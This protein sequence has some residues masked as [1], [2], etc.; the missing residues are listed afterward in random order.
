MRYGSFLPDMPRLLLGALLG[1]SVTV[2]VFV[3]TWLVFGGGGQS[4]PVGVSA[5]DAGPAGP[6]VLAEG[7]AAKRGEKPAEGEPT[8]PKA[9]ATGAVQPANVAG[10]GSATAGSSAAANPVPDA[11]RSNST[12]KSN[13]TKEPAPRPASRRFE[14][15]APVASLTLIQAAIWWCLVL[16]LLAVGGCFGSFM[17]VVIYRL[18]A[19]LSLMR[20]ASRCPYCLEGI[21]GTDNVPVLSWLWLRGQCRACGGAI[22]PRYPLIE[23]LI[24]F[25]CV[26]LALVEVFPEGQG[27]PVEVQQDLRENPWQLWTMFAG[28]LLLLCTLVCAAG[29]QIDGHPVP[30][31]LFIPL[32]LTAVV[33]A[34]MV[35]EACRLRWSVSA[36]GTL[37]GNLIQAMMA[38][39]CGAFAGAS[40]ALATR[41][42]DRVGRGTV[43]MSIILALVTLF[44][45]WITGIVIA[46]VSGLFAAAR[47]RFSRR[48]P[49]LDEVPTV[50]I[51]AG[52]TFGLLLAWRWLLPHFPLLA[53]DSA[54]SFAVATI[55]AALLLSA[56]AWWLGPWSPL[57]WPERGDTIEIIEGQ[58]RRTEYRRR[59]RSPE[60]DES[61]NRD[62]REARETR[63]AQNTR[64]TRESREAGEEPES[65]G[66]G[67][68]SRGGRR[69]TRD[70]LDD[71]Q[72]GEGPE[73]RSANRPEDDEEGGAAGTWERQRG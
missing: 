26:A 64:E 73:V 10:G 36:A 58:Y 15:M 11:S 1:G 18:P 61:E 39:G 22:S 66:S 25:G 4:S 27:L 45:G 20:P 8:A 14:P 28:H 68:S 72:D 54:S 55:V 51:V 65:V 52:A 70:P 19:G 44:L 47:D 24:A 69:R 62:A 71:D 38:A 43:T 46:I 50:A 16:W 48:Y 6:G 34:T 60:S 59:R 12:S 3:G 9:A 56:A 17:N 21:R 7:A 40:L 23:A 57:N 29:I 5:R 30:L 13:T 41:E 32:A 2:V 63:E 49:R 31:R 42:S 33:L 37:S 53:L 35:P 67:A